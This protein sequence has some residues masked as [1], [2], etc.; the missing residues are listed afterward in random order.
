MNKD[1][2]KILGVARN[3]SYDEIKK[4]YH[5]KAIEF[6]PDKNQGD[7]EFEEKF[8]LIVEAYEFLCSLN[9]EIKFTRN[10]YD[11]KGFCRAEFNGKYGFIGN[12]G[13]WKIQPIFDDV[14][15]KSIV[16]E[17]IEYEC[18]DEKD[19]CVAKLEEKYGFINRKGDWIIPPMYD[20]VGMYFNND[21]CMVK[22]IGKYGFINRKGNWKIKP[23]L[24]ES[25]ACIQI[26][27]F[28][29]IEWDI[30]DI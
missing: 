17:V 20:E 22:I 28:T 6:H 3:A 15:L 23:T 13:E 11:N 14:G 4:A 24:D 25:E 7:K 18:F 21:L 12:K 19:Y 26:L 1:Y 8:K 27:S 2:H 16:D 10:E 29:P 9:K 30:D 5:K